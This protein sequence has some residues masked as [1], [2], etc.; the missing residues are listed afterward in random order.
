MDAKH[1]LAQSKFT[2]PS[3]ARALDLG[4]RLLE[5]R[6]EDFIRIEKMS[7]A[8]KSLEALQYDW[9]WFFTWCFEGRT[10]DYHNNCVR[11]ALPAE[12]QTLI[13]FIAYWVGL[14][15]PASI[16]RCLSSI[17]KIHLGANL[18]NPLDGALVSSMAKKIGRGLSQSEK[19]EKK[20]LIE[21]LNKELEAK[22][23]ELDTTLDR[24]IA[25]YVLE[26]DQALVK[27]QKD[28]ERVLNTI[29]PAD[30][31]SLKAYKSAF[32]H[33]QRIIKANFDE[34]IKPIRKSKYLEPL[35]QLPK[36]WKLHNNLAGEQRQAKGLKW[37]HIHRIQQILSIEPLEL[38][39]KMPARQKALQE[40]KHQAKQMIYARNRA[41]AA[42]AYDTLCRASEI[43]NFTI[44]D[45]DYKADGHAHLI[46]RKS[47]TNQE[48][49][50]KRKFISKQT[51]SEIESWLDLADL[52]SGPIFCSVDKSG[53]IKRDIANKIQKPLTP[54]SLLN[55]YKKLAKSI[56]E[57][58]ELFSCHSTRVGATQDMVAGN[59]G[60]AAIKLS[61]DWKSDRMPSRY[62]EGLEVDLG[63]M[64]Q[65]SKAQKR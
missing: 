48:G 33:K 47:K 29:N 25:P 56:G 8:E 30:K 41:I 64:A 19:K 2:F 45:I 21:K 16:R 54:R 31:A 40:R 35:K 28:H 63:G 24:L 36:K 15:A 17:A 6:L 38:P 12:P 42:V 1:A 62:A 32:A 22:K 49:K 57:E 51:V 55:I 5:Q 9:E 43:V 11:Q 20:V 37:H 46:L 7:M 65:L 14:R 26:R 34:K 10:L 27:A 50:K 58:P 44:E 59:I 18:P 3:N 13:D 39:E 4:Q 60:M 23:N 52:V 53:R 61:G